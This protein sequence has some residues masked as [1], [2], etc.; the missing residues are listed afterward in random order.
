[1]AHAVCQD[2]PSDATRDDQQPPT[3]TALPEHGIHQPCVLQLRQHEQELE[4]AR[5]EPGGV[6]AWHSAVQAARKGPT[7]L[8]LN[9]SQQWMASESNHLFF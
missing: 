3:R 8:N 2:Y 1:M 9:K 5:L 6:S 7:L 4:E